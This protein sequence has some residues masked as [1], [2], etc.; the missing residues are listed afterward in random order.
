MKFT[1][2]DNQTSFTLNVE[3]YEFPDE[4]LHPT[5]D[6]PADEFDTGRFLIVSHDCKT[7]DGEWSVR[8]PTMKTTELDQFAKWLESI[9]L[10]QPDAEG[11][12]FT[13]RELELT[14][15]SFQRKLHVHL[16][17]EFLPPMCSELACRLSFPLQELDLV[18]AVASIREQ[19][20]KFPG[21]PTP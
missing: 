14:V 2:S 19:L 6:N 12:C 21:R 16:S 20:A 5:E 13:E 4:E 17:G 11:V 7:P 18:S 10:G 8:G 9:I 3:R 1:T 15:D